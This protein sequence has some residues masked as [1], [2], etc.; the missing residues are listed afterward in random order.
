MKG[1]V[2]GAG[3]VQ[4]RAACNSLQP[5]SLQTKVLLCD[6]NKQS[7][8]NSNN[9]WCEASR[10][11]SS[12]QGLCGAAWTTLTTRPR[13]VSLRSCMWLRVQPVSWPLRSESSRWDQIQSTAHLA[14]RGHTHSVPGPPRPLTVPLPLRAPAEPA[15]CS[16]SPG[17][18]K[19]GRQRRGT[20]TMAGKW[21]GSARTTAP[22]QA[23]PAAAWHA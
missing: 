23:V 14:P 18:G 16:G 11:W 21:L 5:A 2:C 9:P 3:K 8:N 4:A 15:A 6:L 10:L 20:S 17:R 19:P 7:S 12:H 1:S 13:W 22:P